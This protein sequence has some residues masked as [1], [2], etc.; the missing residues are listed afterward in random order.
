MII[1]LR[2]RLAK[3]DELFLRSKTNFKSSLDFH[4][5]W[6]T[7]FVQCIVQNSYN[8]NVAAVYANNGL[9]LYFDILIQNKK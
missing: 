7:L 8:S 1:V 6:D 4:V 3:V 9:K 5:Y 2:V